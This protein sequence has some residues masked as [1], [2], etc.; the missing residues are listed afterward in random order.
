[1]AEVGR[2]PYVKTITDGGSQVERP[3][4]HTMALISLNYPWGSSF[5]EGHDAAKTDARDPFR[6]VLPGCD[7]ALHLSNKQCMEK[8]LIR[9]LCVM[10][11]EQQITCGTVSDA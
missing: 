6:K 1:M 8:R 10:R 11:I 3:V 5:E 2:N 4:L 9:L 7:S